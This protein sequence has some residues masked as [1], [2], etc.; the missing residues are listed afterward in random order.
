MPRVMPCVVTLL[1]RTTLVLYSR[2]PSPLSSYRDFVPI[3]PSARRDANF[4]WRRAGKINII[5]T[6]CWTSVEGLTLLLN[7]HAIDNEKLS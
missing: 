2:P 7:E 4:H 5:V 3:V 6:L 1:D